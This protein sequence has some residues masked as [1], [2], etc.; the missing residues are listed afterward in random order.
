MRRRDL[1]AL[2]VLFVLFPLS[3]EAGGLWLPGHGV[4]PLGRGGAVVANDG[5][6]NGFWYNPGV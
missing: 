6:L 1:I 5:D 3:A 4:G 2:I